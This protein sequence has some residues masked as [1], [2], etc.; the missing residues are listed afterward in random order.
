MSSDPTSAEMLE[1]ADR[2]EDAVQFL[3]A[4]ARGMHLIDWDRE[5]NRLLD[6]AR[7]LRALASRDAKAGG[8]DLREQVAGVIYER[9]RSIMDLRWSELDDDDRAGKLGT[10]DA[11][12][13]LDLLAAALAEGERAMREPVSWCQPPNCGKATPRLFIVRYD[14]TEM[15]DVY[16][17]DE[18]EA[19]AHFRRANVSWNC[20]LFGTLPSLTRE[21][22]PRT[23]A[24]LP[25]A[26]PS[27]P[28]A[29]D[30]E[31]AVLAEREA[32]L[33]LGIQFLR[34]SQFGINADNDAVA[35]YRAAIRARTS[36]AKEER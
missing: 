4:N 29:E 20:Y 25:L 26:D 18:A 14:D 1:L 13:S 16:F 10:A 17:T 33:A 30:V 36:P 12:L 15:P 31:G 11:I 9:S 35:A 28:P 5:S 23:S 27:P 19:R 21:D 24:N 22:D 6:M 7:A 2:G 8:L 3:A 34:P 32:I